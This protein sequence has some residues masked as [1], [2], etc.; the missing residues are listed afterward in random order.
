MSTN[1]EMHVATKRK[2]K[3]LKMIILFSKKHLKYIMIHEIKLKIEK[4]RKTFPKKKRTEKVLYATNS[5]RFFQ[6]G[7]FV[8]IIG[9]MAEL[10]S[11]NSHR[12]C[13]GTNPCNLL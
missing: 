4:I 3:L 13:R 8:P 6:I 9:E 1:T 12:H 10:L 7:K 2:G 5:A 11:A